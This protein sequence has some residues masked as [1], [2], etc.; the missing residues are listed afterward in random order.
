MT[1][2]WRAADI[3]AEIAKIDLIDR[4][5]VDADN[6]GIVGVVYYCGNA[7]F[8]GIGTEIRDIVRRFAGADVEVTIS[9][10][11]RDP[12]AFVRAVIDATVAAG[13]EDGEMEIEGGEFVAPG[14]RLAQLYR[15]A[16]L[17]EMEDRATAGLSDM[18]R[19]FS[20][21]W[22]WR[23][24]IARYALTSEM[25]VCTADRIDAELVVLTRNWWTMSRVPSEDKA[26]RLM[27]IRQRRES[28][29]CN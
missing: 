5:R 15:F 3:A 12:C 1:V 6:P 24:E 29:L 17:C 18:M 27:W 8:P 9:R 23:A 22:T 28:P 25:T 21:N 7:Y 14:D 13:Q 19:T 10:G 4:V 11:D 20:S 16:K 2:T 26:N